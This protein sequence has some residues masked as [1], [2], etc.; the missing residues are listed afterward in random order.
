MLKNYILTAFRSFRK[1][2]F[3]TLINILGLSLGISASAFI[4]L[5]VN[6]ESSYDK[7]FENYESIY[8]LE[9]DFTIHN[10]H[11]KFAVTAIPLG[12]AFKN[13]IPEVESFARFIQDEHIVFKYNEKEFYEKQSFFADSTAPDMFTLSFIDGNRSDALKHPFTA[14]ISESTAKKYFGDTQAYGKVLTDGDGRGYKITGV[15]KD[16]PKNTHMPFDVLMSM[17]SMAT[18]AGNERFNSMDPGNFWNVQVYTFIKVKGD[19]GK[20]LEDSKALVY[21]KY[22]KVV[23]DQLN[24]SFAAMATRL[25]HIH[26][27]DVLTA[28][29]PAGNKK[30]LYIMGLVGLMILILAAINYMNLATAR[31]TKRAREIGLRKVS[32]ADRVMLAW[33]FI[34]ES[35]VLALIALIISFGLI[36]FF[37]PLFNEMADKSLELSIFKNPIVFLILFSIAIV[38]GIISGLYPAFYLSSFQPS[39]VLKGKISIGKQSGWL[40]KGLVTFQ[41]IITVIM[42]T[43][44]IFIYNQ[45]NFLRSAELGFNK[46]NLM[47]MEIQDTA[48]IRK[49]DRF[50]EELRE[51]PKITGTALSRSVPGS[52]ISIQLMKVEKEGRMEEVALNNIACNHEFPEVMGMEFVAGRSFDK[53]NKTDDTTAVIVNEAAARALGWGDEALGKKI[54]RGFGLDGKGG[55]NLKVIGVVKDFHFLSLHNK[56]EPIMLFIPQFPLNI[57]SVR[58]QPGYN[59]STIDFIKSKWESFGNNRPFDYYFLDE[60]FDNKYS[61]EAQL[62][63]VF[64]TFAVISIFIALMGLIGLSSF[65]TAQRTK[66]IGVRKVLG[67]SVNGIV[68]LLYR[69]SII[70]VLIAS[71]IALPVSYYF[72][73]NWLDNYAYHISLTWWTFLLSVVTA[74]IVCLIS[75]SYHTITAATSNPVKS[76]KYE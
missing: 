21:D 67:A 7:H 20:V 27:N 14:V 54:N 6:E 55:R 74:I 32:G 75:I 57:V 53:A 69:E 23:G 50:R 66:E 30:Y 40:R 11:D 3:Y 13:E 4:L 68:G 65:I 37:M 9:S 17:E 63:K 34:T 72:I 39:N 25:D 10:K 49:I 38:M 46:E 5:Y 73:S 16:L 71:A 31:A 18:L 22:M 48:F 70:L 61:S 19:I 36:T 62:G 42:I 45:L 35:I 8:R 12:A 1:S 29:F 76:I 24:A 60:S 41:L 56:V 15:F 28:D 47:V 64:A 51:N 58:L 59:E 2:K 33:Q 43:G 44:T 52:G 26:H